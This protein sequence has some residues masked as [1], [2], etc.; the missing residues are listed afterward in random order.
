MITVKITT[1][2]QPKLDIDGASLVSM[3]SVVSG[4]V[5]IAEPMMALIE[6]ALQDK[7]WQPLLRK[8]P[9]HKWYTREQVLQALHEILAELDS[10]QSVDA[11]FVQRAR[12]CFPHQWVQF[13]LFLVCIQVSGCTYT[14]R[15]LLQFGQYLM[16][17]RHDSLQRLAVLCLSV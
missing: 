8:L 17:I 15:S 11:Q 2:C 12:D 16:L 13:F 5:L 14:S 1:V 9:Q 10:G 6:G 4:L 3:L 7:V